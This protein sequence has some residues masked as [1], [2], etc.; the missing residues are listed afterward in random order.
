[1]LPDHMPTP[2]SLSRERSVT[3]GSSSDESKRSTS[4]SDTTEAMV[5]CRY[6]RAKLDASLG[7]AARPAGWR[8][9]GGGDG[10][11]RLDAMYGNLTSAPAII[12]VCAL[13]L[14]ADGGADLAQL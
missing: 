13:A 5:P 1:M 9:C 8:K 14:S 12:A 3:Y 4:F 7:S 11:W 6:S 2:C 10:G